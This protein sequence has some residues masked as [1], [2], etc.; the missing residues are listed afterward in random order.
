MSQ[1]PPQLQLQWYGR[2]TVGLQRK[3]NEDSL[4]ALGLA[5]A[6][7][8]A[9]EGEGNGHRVHGASSPSPRSAVRSDPAARGEGDDAPLIG[10]EVPVAAPGALLAVADGMGGAKAGE[11]ASGMAVS[12]LAD[13]M[14]QGADAVAARARG[15]EEL[16]LHLANAVLLAHERIR[17]EGFSNPARTGM[18]TTL[19]AAWLIDQRVAFAHVGDSRAYY[20]RA[21]HLKQITRDQSLVEKLLEDKIITPEEAENMVG[22]RNII[23][24]ALG[25]EEDLEVAAES[26]DLQVGDTLL[27]CTDG[28]SGPA[29]DETIQGALR[30]GGSLQELGERLIGEAER[31]GG[32]DNITVL[33]ARVDRA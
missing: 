3:N 28:L 27:L 9:S 29:N 20:F 32:P 10:L 25:S 30:R 31:A 14:R 13:A 18:G 17:D 16:H 33:L 2:T 23:L 21:G 1:T 12:I 4:C 26:L 19:T 6:S 15:I 11:V 5:A 24:Q 7:E 22:S 8:G